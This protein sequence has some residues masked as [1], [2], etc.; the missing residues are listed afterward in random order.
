MRRKF[1]FSIKK[2]EK[3]KRAISTKIKKGKKLKITRVMTLR[4]QR[5]IISDFKRNKDG[6]NL[7][8]ERPS[9]FRPSKIIPF[10]YNVQIKLI[11][12]LLSRRS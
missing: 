5:F 6:S 1:C 11:L 3:S 12:S 10:I 2:R 9:L 4:K 8:L 7:L